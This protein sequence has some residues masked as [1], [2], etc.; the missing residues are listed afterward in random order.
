MTPLRLACSVAMS[1]L[2]L[3]PVHGQATVNEVQ[4][5]TG[6]GG[7]FLDNFG[8][9]VSILG[10]RAMVGAMADDDMGS[11]TL[12]LRQGG[13]WVEGQKLTSN[14]RVPGDRFGFSVAL[15]DD[16]VLI[17]A[18]GD[19]DGASGSG[20]VYVFEHLAGNWRQ[21]DKLHAG[22]AAG[23]DNFGRALD[24]SGSVAVIGAPGKDDGALNAGAAYVFR[25]TGGT[26]VEEQALS[27]LVPGTQ[28]AFGS[29]VAID[30]DVLVVSSITDDTLANDAGRVDVYRWDG[31]SWAHEQALLA[32]DGAANEW[33]GW[34]VDVQGDVIAV[35]ANHHGLPATYAGAV[36]M[37]R[38]GGG[39]WVEEQ[40]LTHSGA[41]TY[42]GFGWS[43]ALSGHRLVAGAAGW[44]AG[45]GDGAAFQFHHD[46]T[47]WVEVQRWLTSDDGSGG[48]FLPNL[49]LSIAVEG[50]TVMSGSPWADGS[51]G[52]GDAGAI[53]VFEADNLA[54]DVLP[55]SPGPTASAEFR[56]HGG[57]AGGQTAMFVL[58]LGGVPLTAQLTLGAFDI[59]GRHSFSALVPASM[60]GVDASFIAVGQWK[61]GTVGLSNVLQ[62]TF[63]N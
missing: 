51:G 35:G 30:G 61:P 45:Y 18:E 50:K 38:W 44:P 19:D 6:T 37:F 60:A 46:G 62:M 47:R 58:E 57:L 28:S 41:Q 36:Y 20:S 25:N 55:D 40:K 16:L 29:A 48:I 54:L 1:V 15:L 43:V 26:W 23:T 22:D 63:G 31:G 27:P 59:D 2:C 4:K 3:A 12:L 21:T 42:D 52:V 10:N 13:T 17:G 32:S 7:A 56:T 9:D 39:A 49:G 11:V 5:L 34:S 24:A 53:Y 33:F 14:D 8:R